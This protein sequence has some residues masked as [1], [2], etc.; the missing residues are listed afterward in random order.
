MK[1]GNSDKDLRGQSK[2]KKSPSNLA[3]KR[4]MLTLASAFLEFKEVSVVHSTI[5]CQL[6]TM[7]YWSWEG[8][9]SF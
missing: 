3:T 5:R 4:S 2:S 6:S 8:A 1:M 9:V 7:K